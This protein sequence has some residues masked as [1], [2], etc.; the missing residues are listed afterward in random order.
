M[1][2]LRIVSLLPSATEII[3]ALGLEAQLVG[4]THE[5]DYPPSVRDLPKVT[6]T[7][8]P[9]DATSQEIDHLV[10]ERLQS[11]QAL[12]TLN[13]PVL[14]ALQPDVIVTQALC[15]VCAVAEEEVKAAAC[16]LPGSPQVINLEPQTLEEVFASL[17]QVAAATGRQAVAEEVV[18]GLKARV[19]AV[20]RRS[21]TVDRR[22][23]VALLEWLHP[24]F[25]CGHWSPE[26]VHL[27]GGE[28]VLGRAGVPSRTLTW[29]EV[30]AA[31]PE[32][33]FVACCGFSVERTLEDLDLLAAHPVWS[34]LPAVRQGQVYVTDGSH[35]FSRPG[36]RLVESLEILAHALHPALHPRPAVEPAI[37]HRPKHQGAAVG[38]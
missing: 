5:C 18:A 4:V 31:R 32:V 20:V 36:P 23:R 35:Y 2:D 16:R 14:E 26:L 34:S 30:A 38:V 17:H 29:E 28:E 12:Y 37:A 1:T 33:V 8:I 13:L 7:L 3:C 22:P 21:A 25:S 19:E 6:H 24:P 15:D 9:T 11:V 10:R 27:A